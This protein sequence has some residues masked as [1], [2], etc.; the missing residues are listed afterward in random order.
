MAEGS[1]A[2]E[3][4]ERRQANATISR[5]PLFPRKRHSSTRAA[6]PLSANSGHSLLAHRAALADQFDLTRPPRL[7]EERFERTVKTQDREPSFLRI[8][9][10]PVA[11]AHARG[12]GR[13]EI[14]GGDAVGT[15]VGGGRRIALAD[16]E[17]ARP[18][19]PY[20]QAE[21]TIAHPRADGSQSDWNVR[22]GS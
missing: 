5:C 20:A 1:S 7:R 18:K 6:C 10:N 17:G 16:V 4:T 15:R 22:F 12:F 8:G 19:R 2:V 11:I 21:R 14:H 13:S 3:G 9:L